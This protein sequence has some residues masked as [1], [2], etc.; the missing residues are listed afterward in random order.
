MGGRCRSKSPSFVVP[1]PGCLLVCE[2]FLVNFFQEE[3]HS[4]LYSSLEE[5]MRSHHS[6]PC[7]W[8]LKIFWRHFRVNN[9]K[10]VCNYTSIYTHIYVTF[11]QWMYCLVSSILTDFWLF[12]DSFTDIKLSL[13]LVEFGE[14]LSLLSFSPFQYSVFFPSI[15]PSLCSEHWG[16]A[17]RKK[18]NVWVRTVGLKQ[19]LGNYKGLTLWVKIRV[20]VCNWLLWCILKAS[21]SA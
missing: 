3:K 8:S 11:Y 18:T 7:C 21:F 5:I 6:V 1:S 19:G 16:D 10:P 17:I 4:C 14:V 20:I 13:H 12:L 2:V 9:Y 15:P